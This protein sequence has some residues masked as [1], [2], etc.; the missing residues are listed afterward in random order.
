MKPLKYVIAAIATISLSGVFGLGYFCGLEKGKAIE[1]DKWNCVDSPRVR[2]ETYT[3]SEFARD[4]VYKEMSRRLTPSD[5]ILA[6]MDVNGDR[7]I[8]PFEH[9]DWRLKNHLIGN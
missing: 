4:D 8:H 7:I 3:L 5:S 9:H 2:M 1:R 6:E